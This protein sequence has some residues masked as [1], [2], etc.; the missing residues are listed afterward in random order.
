VL[1]V[2]T[3]LSLLDVESSGVG[4][5][6]AALGVGG[7]IGGFVALVLATRGRLAA[8]FG[9]GIALFGIPLAL[10]GITSSVVVALLA[11]ALI[12]LAN[13][14]VDINALTIMQRAVPDEVLAR[15]LG[16][17]EGILIG[18]IGV[19]G[20]LAPVLIHFAGIRWALILT[21]LLLP[22]LAHLSARAHRSPARH[23]VAG[24]T[25]AGHARGAGRFSGGAVRA[26]RR[27]DRARGRGG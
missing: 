26:G 2:V 24:T 3:A 8:D 18:S 17:L 15:V 13:S 14:I 7:L 22:V 11:L 12:G 16:V 6:N 27:R 4:Y 19:G 9:I 1:V 5:L 25:A 20:L 10:I 23:R 21:G